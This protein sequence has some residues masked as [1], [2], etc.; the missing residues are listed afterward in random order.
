MTGR[1]VELERG[2]LVKLNEVEDGR[3][4][5]FIKRS[6]VVKIFEG[7][8]GKQ[9]AILATT[10]HRAHQKTRCAGLGAYQIFDVS[11]S[12]R[13]LQASTTCTSKFLLFLI[14]GLRMISDNP[15]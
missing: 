6:T 13:S 5:L 8:N 11:R 15:S 7:V 2:K 3:S 9:V 10:S 14:H 1:N 4:T 12:R